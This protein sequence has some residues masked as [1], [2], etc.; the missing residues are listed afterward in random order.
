MPLRCVRLLLLSPA[1]LLG[2]CGTVSQVRTAFEMPVDPTPSPQELARARHTRAT[3]S[4]SS[5][6][7]K[8]NSE[9][10]GRYF[11]SNKPNAPRPTP[12]SAP[13]PLGLKAQPARDLA[14]DL[15]R[16]QDVPLAP[17]Q[18]RVAL[19]SSGVARSTPVPSTSDAA[20][21]VLATR[22]VKTSSSRTRGSD[23]SLGE[24]LRAWASRRSLRRADDELLRQRA[25]EDRIALQTRSV[26]PTLDLSLVS[27]ETQLKLTN[28]RLQLIPLLSI[29]V[30]QRVQAKQEIEDIEKSLNQI[31]A[32]ETDRQ[33]KLLNQALVDVPARLRQEGDKVIEA[34]TR[35]D[36]EKTQT[37]LAQVRDSTQQNLDVIS[38]PSLGIIQRSATAPDG[39][40]VRSAV[41]APITSTPSGSI[42]SRP[43]PLPAEIGI[44]RREPGR[45]GKSAR[46]MAERTERIWREATR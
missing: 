36:T 4:L 21:Q 28:L 11:S 38:L 39:A 17:R 20:T 27:P 43:A 34:N 40:K 6:L 41:G 12:T 31:W 30:A 23:Q 29:P 26:R 14:N 8:L 45:L 46:N 37:R 10:L 19:S 35:L 42:P 16:S 15:A 3:D 44:T 24:F 5:S 18:V 7:T 25:L 9:T 33:S 22:A 32:E 13:R 2:G 1:L